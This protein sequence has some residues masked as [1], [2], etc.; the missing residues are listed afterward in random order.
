MARSG[1]W[2]APEALWFN[3]VRD[4]GWTCGVPRMPLRSYAAPR[5]CEVPSEFFNSLLTSERNDS[6][7]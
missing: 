6:L 3:P 5:L 4:P 1:C 2:A 7:R